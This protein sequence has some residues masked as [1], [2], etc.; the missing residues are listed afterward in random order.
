MA[1]KQ[2]STS[3]REISYALIQFCAPLILSGILQQLYNWAD[4][5]IVGNVEGEL[6][7]AAVGGT[8]TVINF[9]VAIITGFTLGLTI[10]FAQKYGSGETA[11]FSRI[12]SAF[13]VF[14]T[15]IFVVLAAMGVWLSYP[16]LEL[17][18]TPSD[19]IAMAADYLRIIFLGV[20][21]LAVYNV[22]SA[23]IRGMGN[24]RA[25]FYS[26]LL[27]S[28]VNVVL[29][30][31][32]VA[33]LHT[34]VAG[35]A[36]ATVISQAAMTVYLVFY[37]IRRYHLRLQ[38]NRET[39]RRAVFAQGFHFGL[40]PM[41]QSSVSSVGNIF[42]QNFMNGFGTQTVAAITTAYRV[43]SIVLLPII[44][45]GSGISTLTAHS[46]GSG[47]KKRA[48]KTLA[49]G[50]WIMIG[51]SLLLT[52][53]VIPTGG[54]LIG[55][56]GAGEQAISIG[57]NFFRRIAVFYVVF[58]LATAV[59]GYLE[60]IGDVVYSGFSGIVSLLL[61][62]AASYAL[63]A[64]FGNMVIAYAEGFSWIALLGLYVLRL[65]YQFSHAEKCVPSD[66]AD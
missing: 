4:A 42:L 28:I 18:H 47:D 59:R 26:V 20:P 29:D 56:F 65:F 7:L 31:L 5:F 6:A 27:S 25:P 21:F 23:A 32:L 66:K 35:A 8:S 19:T 3:F 57:E 38:L 52:I 63:A 34:G 51:V 16:L 41:L 12:L 37:G 15:G 39:F 10:L 43:D 17:L 45:L 33:Y 44:N 50:I 55:M 64:A 30:I 61:R 49:A 60:G 40:P 53:I 2:T 14:L 11:G 22:Y 1:A 36:V 13:A 62:I 54:K 9:Y 58:G 24:S 46:W 48:R